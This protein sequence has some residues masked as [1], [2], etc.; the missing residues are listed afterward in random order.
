MI[1]T[2]TVPNVNAFGRNELSRSGHV[3][4]DLG[5]PSDEASAPSSDRVFVGASGGSEIF[6]CSITLWSPRDTGYSPESLAKSSTRLSVGTGSAVVCS[7]AETSVKPRGL[8]R[9][10][11]R[12]PAESHAMNEKMKI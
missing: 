11:R 9:M 2:S 8:M 7:G 5:A 1:A 12:Y 6:M 4:V 3:Q 10:P